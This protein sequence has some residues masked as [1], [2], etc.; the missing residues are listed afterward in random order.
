[1]A[2]ITVSA[3]I[4]SSGAVTGA[5]TFRRALDTMR[6]GVATTGRTLSGLTSQ[7]FSFQGAIA[8]AFGG[9]SAKGIVEASDSFIELKARLALVVQEG[10]TVEQLLG[11][12]ADAAGRARA[13]TLEMATLY[14]RNAGALQ[15][16]GRSSADG[17]R[18]AETLAKVTAISGASAQQASAGMMQLSQAIASG[19]FQGDEF[20]SVAENIPEVMR[21]LQR[22]TGKTAGELRKL[23]SEGKLT[24]E[25]LVNAMLN[26][27]AEVDAKFATMPQTAGRA[28]QALTDG[29]TR[30]FGEIAEKT[31]LSES[32]ARA[33]DA[34][35]EAMSGPAFRDAATW[36]AESLGMIAGK[37]KWLA[38]NVNEA[39]V[40]YESWKRA[41]Q[42]S[43][44]Y[45]GITGALTALGNGYE[46]LKGKISGAL[47]SLQ[48][49]AG[50]TGP[51]PF[52]AMAADAAKYA[53]QL[54]IATQFRDGLF[55]DSSTPDAPKSTAP[56]KKLPIVFG[57]GVDEAEIKRKERLGI[58]LARNLDIE[59]MRSE[60]S[61][62]EKANDQVKA[63]ALRAEI[64]IRGSI[65]DEMRKL[66]P[67]LAAQLER[68]ILISEEIRRQEQ[69]R[70]ESIATAERFSDVMIS[71][72][73]AM[74]RE[75]ASFKDA[76]KQ[77][78][79]E[80]LQLINQIL[81][82]EPLKKQLT[83][84]MSGGT[85]GG[86]FDFGGALNAIGGAFSPGGA[87]LSLPSLSFAKSGGSAPLALPPLKSMS[88]AKTAAADST[89]QQI[90]I[91]I[92]GDATDETVEKMRRVAQNEFAKA[93]PG[94]IKRS[95]AEVR[96][97]HV[98][99]KN[100][101]RR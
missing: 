94:L 59:R 83:S 44:F 24:G 58:Q 12:I 23:A 25:V 18:L 73:E 30:A 61:L 70:K 84:F 6:Q 95:A 21:T 75:G 60:L 11:G 69:L 14:Q 13:P 26:A 54:R 63:S 101:L 41:L 89:P 93:S 81:I 38:E 68:E 90:V 67:A 91:N 96:R 34:I 79:R 49:Q 17:I 29:A 57:S 88:G 7:L 98:A 48:A 85:G 40:Q 22:E 36:L 19:R 15:D 53:E 31:K 50:A 100:F 9:L 97:M 74:S 77:I 27:A 87:G 99:D 92:S 66:Q 45:Q 51:T 28:W 1:M 56:A 43:E 47:D 52:E 4:N 62:A 64:E 37:V 72:L 55:D 3:A 16:M 32:W 76:L 33:F 2:D 20:R 65:T 5:A 80:M 10:Q 8:A 82:L 46:W 71:G 42:D 35:R 78:G 86:G 39:R